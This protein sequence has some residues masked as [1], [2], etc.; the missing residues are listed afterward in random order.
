MRRRQT[1]CVNAWAIIRPPFEP[2]VK[3]FG[4]QKNSGRRLADGTLDCILKGSATLCQT[5]R[6]ARASPCETG[7]RCVWFPK[8]GAMFFDLERIRANVRQA[9]TEDL[10]DRVT[11]Y[12]PE[13]EEAA[14]VC[15]EEELRR[16]GIAPVE[17][18]EHEESRNR[19]ILRRPDGHPVRCSRC[20]R[21]A[22]S[23]ATGWHRLWGVLPL[24]RRSFFYCEEHSSPK[25]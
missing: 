11:V 23:Q 16:R 9:E 7:I 3:T 21:P 2:M 4:I 18:S 12:R 10:L 20:Y 5:E 24:F 6:S 14:L 13:M 8:R 25:R 17:I 15:I 1:R 22:V 19:S